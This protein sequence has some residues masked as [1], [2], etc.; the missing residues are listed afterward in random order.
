ML[1]L[2]L[3]PFGLA[4]VVDLVSLRVSL[5]FEQLSA[6]LARVLGLT[7]VVFGDLVSE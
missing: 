3:S 2:V 6:H 7:E 1:A 4:S 5:V